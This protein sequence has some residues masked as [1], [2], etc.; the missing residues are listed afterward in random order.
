MVKV[1]LDRRLFM[2]GA[3]GLGAT[4]LAAPAI[5]QPAWPSQNIRMV[6]PFPPGGQGDL[7][8][9][10]V[11][12]SLEK[13]L[14]KPV[15]VDNRGGAGGA[16][17]NAAVAKS[18]PDGHTL[19]MTLSSLA[20]LPE[21]DRIMGRQAQYE[22]DQLVPIARVLADPTLLAVNARAPWK[23][24]AELATDAKARPGQIP[25]GSSG[26]YGTLH[27][28]MEMFNTNASLRMNH[29]PYRGAGPAMTDLISGNIQALASAPGVLKPQVDAGSIRVLANFGAERVP[30][31]PDTPTFKELGF[32]DV[33]FYIWAGLFVPARTPAS[34]IA[35]LREAMKTTM[36]DPEVRNVYERAGSPPAYLDQPEFMQFVQADSGRLIQAVRKI[37]RVDGG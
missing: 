1:Q 4:G 26:P 25:Y 21:A 34:V 10:P 24:V 32:S 18:D 19:L 30:S 6:V 36:A 20:V 16:L 12:Q 31:F 35:R 8:A 7:A 29:I 17:G 28:S 11:A 23:T 15:V 13:L 2:A 3:A 33:E 27:V 22:V 9:R 37:G 14:G 5:G